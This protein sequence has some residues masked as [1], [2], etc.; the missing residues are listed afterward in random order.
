MEPLTPTQYIVLSADW[1][2]STMC[3]TVVGYFIRGKICQSVRSFFS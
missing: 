2:Q 3:N 1:V